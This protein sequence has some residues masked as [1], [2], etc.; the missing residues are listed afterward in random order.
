MNEKMHGLFI[1]VPY[2]L[3]SIYESGIA[4]FRTLERSERLTIDYLEVDRNKNEIPTKYD[5][6][7]FNYHWVKMGWLDTRYLRKKL[8]NIYAISLE[9]EP[10]NPLF[11]FLGDDF[12]GYFV[13]DPTISSPR[14]NILGLPRPIPDLYP[15]KRRDSNA[16]SPI[17]GTFGLSYCEK[18]FDE[19]VRAV[20]R[21][22]DTA[23]VKINIPTLPSLPID[24]ATNFR[25]GIA[26]LV[27]GTNV[28]TEITSHN[29]SQAELISWC[30][31]NDLN[32]FFYT[33]RVGNGLAATTD[34]AVAS[35]TPI[36]ISTNPTFRHLMSAIR[37]YPYWTLRDAILNGPT[38]IKRL[39]E[40]WSA[41]KLINEVENL[42]IGNWDIDANPLKASLLLPQRSRR[43]DLQYKLSKV[44][45]A[46]FVPPA[47]LQVY[48]R[49]RNR[50]LMRF[51]RDYTE[52]GNAWS[53]TNPFFRNNSVGQYSHALLESY[54]HANEDLL[55]DFLIGKKSK[56]VYV[57]VGANDPIF[58][59]NTYRFYKRGW[60][61]IN[62]DPNLTSITR[63]NQLRQGDNNIQVAVSDFSGIGNLQ[64]LGVDTSI[65]SL[66]RNFISNMSKV[67]GMPPVSNEITVTTLA[68]VLSENLTDDSIDFLSV[69]AEG[70][71]LEVLKGNNWEKYRPNFVLVEANKGASE[72]VSFMESQNYLYLLSN[73]VNAFF[74]DKHFESEFPSNR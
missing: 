53:S 4:F 67:T 7:I 73:G 18:G 37:P 5:F 42:V 54:S 20:V 40:E 15:I 56:G 61:G 1:N 63:L 30:A 46:Y 8:Q 72:I 43:R 19:V 50:I 23:T 39:Q 74:I 34:Q 25:E 41:S 62:I 66:N 52:V 48:S 57:D 2:D 13:L 64:T 22:F 31:K 35:G 49:T 60:R 28:K 32:A 16:D 47:I 45:V 21:E 38:A 44:G 51:K 6:Y 9:V 3:C 14:S 12:D 33:R 24:E 27:L 65:S 70:N 58:G 26:K 68:Q 69:D 17:V 59:N 10:N 29:F 71:D 36:A 11:G 55:L